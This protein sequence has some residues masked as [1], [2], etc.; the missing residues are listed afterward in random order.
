MYLDDVRRVRTETNKAYLFLEFIRAVFSGIGADYVERL[1]PDLER[2]VRVREKTVVVRGRIDAVLG[3]LLV[4]FESDLRFERKLRQ[5]KE[6][7]RRYIA[8]LW[9]KSR[10]RRFNYLAVATDGLRFWVYRPVCSV[11]PGV[12]VSPDDVRLEELESFDLERV[13]ERE[14][15]L[16]LDRIFLAGERVPVTTEGF[17]NDFGPKSPFFKLFMQDVNNL[18]MDIR[19][20]AE[21]RVLYDEWAR[22]LRIV[23]GTPVESEELFFKHT[24]LATLAKLMAFMVLNGGRIPSR[25]DLYEILVGEA[26]R[27]WGILNL[28]EEDYFSWLVRGVTKESG[29]DLVE[30][31][32]DVLRR[33]D[34]SSLDEDVMKS[35]YQELVDPA[36]RHD[37][38]EYYTPDWL[39]EYMLK[40][41]LGENAE[42]K[43]LDPACGSG[44]FLFM[45]IEL[46]KELVRLKGADL[47]EHIVGNV[48][49]IDVHPLAVIVSKANY[50]L[51]L[52]A[53][54]NE[55]R[56]DVHIPVYLADSIRLPELKEPEISRGAGVA[57]Y[58]FEAGD[59]K[60]YLPE[61]LIKELLFD[62]V[63]L[64]LDFIKVYGESVARGSW[65]PNLESF[66]NGLLRRIPD[67]APLLEKY[68]S[69][70]IEVLYGSALILAELIKSN[71]DT[72]WPFIIKNRYKPLFLRGMFDILVG[73]PPWLSYRY[74]ADPSYQEFL[75][76]LI[77]S[78][79][80]LTSRAELMTHMELATLFFVRCADLY[81]KDGGLIYFVMPRSIYTADQ[82]DKF[83]TG[84]K[85]I[86]LV[87]LVDLKDVTPL[88][89][90][91]ACLVKGVKYGNTRYPIKDSMVVS[92]DLPEKNL[93]L[94][95]AVESLVERSVSLY[96]NTVRSRSWLSDK[97]FELAKG[98]SAYY[99]G[100]SQG[101]TIVPRQFW[102]VDII[103]SVRGWINPRRPYLRTS[104]RASVMAKRDYVGLVIEGNVEAE[105]LYGV[106]TSSELVPF[107]HLP[108]RLAVLPI[109][110]QTT[111]YK[112]LS[113]DE[114]EERGLFGLAE[115][116][117]KCEEEWNKRRGLKA[118]K[119]SVY[120]RL[121]YQKD[122][123]TQNPS[124]KFRVIYPTS[125]TY[126]VSSVIEPKQEP[127]TVI[128]D[129][130]LISLKGLIIDT[131]LYYIVLDDVNE[132]YYLCS[133]LNSQI[134]DEFIK[135]L[136][137]RGQYGPRD[138]HK[139]PLELPIPRFNPSN[140]DHL[141]L[142]ELGKEASDIVARALPKVLED[143]QVEVLTPQHVARIRN[144]IKEV[145]QDQLNQIDELVSNILI[146]H[147]I[148]NLDQYIQ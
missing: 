22:Y 33:Y 46:K 44:T 69:S 47:L 28:F 29:L 84:P 80:E 19:D 137:A 1:F 92:G 126:L 87:K 48:V 135:P 145:L 143:Y 4:E 104:K 147:D 79:Y 90:V 146:Q 43:I 77:S 119:L 38:G 82:H 78:V 11:K 98:R 17:V 89:N 67:I 86:G 116:L 123:T 107:G 140:P 115:W 127:Y 130:T 21:V 40:D 100:F 144:N 41:L 117:R 103:P 61:P 13:D 49:G 93:R 60:L 138:L 36:E 122:L 101:A 113:A 132:A 3:N 128:I 121:D 72:I 54:I 18:W 114:A 51:G 14:A 111:H 45:A 109:E 39:A 56:G 50:L 2:F 30:G 34:L 81:L 5:A 32:L 26:F 52:G 9:P 73:N 16:R 58:E 63:D 94:K 59:K 97:K 108:P 31:F 99:D 35:L 8:I 62:K 64:V 110:P 42:A 148:R 136:Q 91:P 25:D 129:G 83:R 12:P 141:A 65:R 120:E 95:D 88:F 27:R 131:K 53:L 139:K 105:F 133:T 125:A 112:I 10:N 85:G 20:R 37:L 71:R 106:L 68:G 96:L 70:V 134:V 76:E 15:Y 23:Y 102:F 75:K 66:S 6:Q 55:R 124:P 74:V 57:R 118:M 142:S 24:Y 7:L